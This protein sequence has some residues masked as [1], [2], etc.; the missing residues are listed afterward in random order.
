MACFRIFFS[1]EFLWLA[2]LLKGGF[3]TKQSTVSKIL[4]SSSIRSLL[5]ILTSLNS[6]FVEDKETLNLDA[7]AKYGLISLPIIL[8]EFTSRLDIILIKIFPIPHPGSMYVFEEELSPNCFFII[9][10]ISLHTS[11]SVGIFDPDSFLFNSAH[12]WD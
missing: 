5:K 10:V 7:S 11:L 6:A 3:I 8:D 1:Y 2:P 9:E 12:T 4:L